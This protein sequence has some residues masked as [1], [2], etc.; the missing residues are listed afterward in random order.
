MLH[1]IWKQNIYAI[2]VAWILS[3]WLYYSISHN[4]N[5]LFTD[6]QWV[7]WIASIWDVNYRL[8][9]NELVIISTKNFDAVKWISI[10]ISYNNEKV[11]L[12]TN[13]ILGFW[14]IELSNEENSM[15]VTIIPSQKYIPSKTELLHIPLLWTDTSQVVVNDVIV[16]F[17]NGTT[18]SVSVWVEN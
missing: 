2:I 14:D 12:D 16:S 1:T 8:D 17:E 4:S 13:R 3:Y 7:S 9:N 18:D 6:I 11:N 10:L 15:Q 5:W